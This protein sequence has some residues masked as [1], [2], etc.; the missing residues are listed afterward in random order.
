MKRTLY[1][2]GLG[3]LCLMW[4]PPLAHAVTGALCIKNTLNGSLKLRA[5][6]TCKS[7]EIQI[8]SFD[9]TTLQFSGINVQ[10]V[11]GSGATSGTVNGKGNL[12]VGYN[13][14]TAAFPQTGSHNIIIGDDHSYTS[15]GGFVAGFENSITAPGASVSGGTNNIASGFQSSISGG[16]CNLAGPGP[17]PS[18]LIFHS[19]VVSVSGGLRNTASGDHAS[20]SGGNGL[21]Q[22]ATNGWAA[23]TATPG[24]TINGDFESP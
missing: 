21:S 16:E 2:V 3:A 19:G 4:A 12:I 11:S 20:V 7:S 6:G 23:G 14:N 9:G 5:T 10:V 22:P 17:A 24:N 13:G 15:Y 1:A 8:G 18:C